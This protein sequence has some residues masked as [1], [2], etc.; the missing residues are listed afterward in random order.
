MTDPNLEGILNKYR[1]LMKYGPMFKLLKKAPMEDGRQLEYYPPWERDNPS[2]GKA[3]VE[4]YNTGASPQVTE[5]LIAGDMMHYLGGVDP[6][7]G[8]VIDPTWFK[9]K[10]QLIQSRTPEQRQIDA[11]AYERD[12]VLDRKSVV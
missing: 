8:E 1:G 5:N 9:L 11:S 3:T 7:T 10:Q 2:P 4:L 6:R 12:P